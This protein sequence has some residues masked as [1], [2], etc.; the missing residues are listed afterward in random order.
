[1]FCLLQLCLYLVKSI[2]EALLNFSLGLVCFWRWLRRTVLGSLQIGLGCIVW[3]TSDLV[4]YVNW[5]WFGV[6]MV[7]RLPD[8][9]HRGI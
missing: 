4:E 6:V 2:P 9:L 1:M 8:G 5:V 3:M 7:C